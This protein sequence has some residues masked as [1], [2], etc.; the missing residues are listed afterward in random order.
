ML[1]TIDLQL[2]IGFSSVDFLKFS[3]DLPSLRTNFLRTCEEAS[4][5]I[6]GFLAIVR[7]S[8]EIQRIALNE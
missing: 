3:V 6:K 1:S 5:K 2:F 8:W 4:S 7:I